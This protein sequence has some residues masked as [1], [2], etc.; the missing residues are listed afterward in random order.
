MAKI[1]VTMNGVVQQEVF[2]LKPHLSIGRR[3]GND[4]VL[5]HLTISGEH[6]AIDT[7]SNGAFV[8]DLGSTNGTL[9]NGQ[10]ITKHLLQNDDVIDLGKYK[11]KFLADLV[12]ARLETVTQVPIPVLKEPENVVAAKIKVLNGSNAG[13]EISLNRSITKL[14]SPTILVV[15][16]TRHM[17]D[18][19]IT[20]IEGASAPRIN[21][22]SMT[23]KFQK[24][25]DGDVIDLAGTKM[26]FTL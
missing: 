7:T 23:K 5:D 9:V 13:R 18:Y 10:P 20:H 26:I 24:L 25:N 17:P 8:S 14:G 22:K 16:I 1:V 2:M 15:S 3:P 11:L 6:A 19:L 12:S 4:L 21:D